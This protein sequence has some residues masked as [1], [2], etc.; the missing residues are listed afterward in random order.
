MELNL[1]TS[2]AA[3]P[4][5]VEEVENEMNSLTTKLGSGNLRHLTKNR[6]SNS[7]Y[8]NIKESKLREINLVL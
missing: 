7:S 3:E 8:R 6:T 4:D 5:L 2:L 1:C